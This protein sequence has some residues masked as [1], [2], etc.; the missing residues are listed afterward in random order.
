MAA[1]G[2]DKRRD[3][4]GRAGGERRDRQAAR[5]PRGK[6]KGMSIADKNAGREGR[7]ERRKQMGGGDGG[8][9]GA[10]CGNAEEAL[11]RGAG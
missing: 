11:L 5:R 9:A 10:W 2:T 1:V 4:V 8:G 6:R 7:R 3:A